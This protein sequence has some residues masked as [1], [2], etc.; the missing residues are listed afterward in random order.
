MNESQ[1]R[2]GVLGVILLTVFLDLV[3]FSIIFP[4]FPDMLEYYL[5][6]ESA[7]G[8]FHKLIASLEGLSGLQGD[9][10]RFAATVLFGGLLG[11]LYSVLQ[12]AFAPIWGVLSDRR[13]R[14]RILILTVCG[15]ALSYLVWVVAD[16]F[17]L[18]IV[19]RFL[20]GL[21]AG[22]LSVATAAVAD[23]TPIHRHGPKGWE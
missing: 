12:F 19:S 21:M 14:R 1:S 3:G 8:T 22:N 5:G 16:K 7:G 13:G 9:E 10:A 15:T 23:V 6:K 20:G 18:L 2:K 17:W 4:L 11:S